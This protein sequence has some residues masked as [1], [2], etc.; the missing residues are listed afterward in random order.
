MTLGVTGAVISSTV[1]GFAVF[2]LYRAANFNMST[3]VL[4]M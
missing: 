4:L 1:L 2:G 3:Y